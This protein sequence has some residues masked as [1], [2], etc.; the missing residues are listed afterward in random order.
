MFKGF[1]F[2]KEGVANMGGLF[3]KIIHSLYC[4]VAPK[5]FHMPTDVSGS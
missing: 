5:T 4:A 2:L 3:N 1:L